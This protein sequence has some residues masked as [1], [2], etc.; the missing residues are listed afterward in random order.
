M[1]EF[2]KFFNQEQLSETI[3]SKADV[4]MIKEIQQQKADKYQIEEIHALIN[5][6]KSRMYEISLLQQQ[7]AISLVP[8]KTSVNRFDH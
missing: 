2:K 6:L 4:E 1:V 7:M 5:K 3:D 8:S